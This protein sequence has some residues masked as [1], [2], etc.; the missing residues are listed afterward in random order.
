MRI[1]REWSTLATNGSPL[2]PVLGTSYCGE[3][4]RHQR[5]GGQ[6]GTE[7]DRASQDFGQD[8]DLIMVATHAGHAVSRTACFVQKRSAQTK[9]LA[10]I[11]LQPAR[12]FFW[13]RNCTTIHHVTYTRNVLVI[14]AEK[15]TS[16]TNWTDRNTCVL[17]V[18]APARD[19]AHRGAP[20]A[21]QHSHRQRRAVHRHFVHAGRRVAVPYHTRKLDKHLATYI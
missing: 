13:I 18:T 10:S 3:G 2:A 4:R 14:G 19:F 1:S 15:L 20:M 21:Y 6:G 11:F 5:H 7:G 9:P 17:L 12:V 16:I 8:I